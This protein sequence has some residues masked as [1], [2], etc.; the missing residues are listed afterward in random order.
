LTAFPNH[1]SAML[2]H[3]DN[4]SDLVYLFT[5]ADQMLM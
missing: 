4:V 5:V 2:L 1:K 3:I